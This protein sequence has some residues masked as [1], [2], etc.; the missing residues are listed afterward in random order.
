MVFDIKSIF[1]RI[2]YYKKFKDPSINPE[3][4]PSKWFIKDGLLFISLV[5]LTNILNTIAIIILVNSEEFPDAI[6]HANKP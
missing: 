2:L 3:I 1:N 6:S 4:N 5:V